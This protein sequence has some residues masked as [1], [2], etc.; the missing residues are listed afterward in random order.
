MSCYIGKSQKGLSQETEAA[1]S[2]EMAYEY[3]KK[4]TAK[5]H[6]LNAAFN[7]AVIMENI[8]VSYTNRREFTV[9][10]KW[11]AREDEFVRQ[12]VALKDAPPA[13]V[14]DMK[15]FYYLD[16][17]SVALGLNKPDEAARAFADYQKT[18]KAQSCEGR[19]DG[20]DFLFNAKRYAEAADAYAVLDQFFDERNM[21][22]S[23][24]NVG[25][26]TG[27]FEINLHAGRKD[28]AMAVATYVFDRLDSIITVQKESDAAELATVYAT[29]QKDA[30][31]AQQQIKLT[32]QRWVATA[33]ALLLLS[34]FFIIYTLNRRR[35]AKHLAEKNVQ[36]Q[37]AH[38]EL[39]TAY[40]QLEETT[41][42]KER[43]ASELRI[44]RD[45]QMS[46]V[47]SLFPDYD[48]IFLKRK[49]RF[50]PR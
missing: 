21:G 44:A 17:A 46:M 5:D 9:A 35:H 2:Y 7:A 19:I 36:L 30:E 37:R 43:M 18:Q 10:E 27:K 41:A 12:F 6:R 28:S 29:Q 38:T 11:L 20:A 24:D 42:Q 32:Q 15:A 13:W 25:F 34:I 45:I 31:I 22:L 1:K 16:Y 48:V 4:M 26:L 14:D 33:I 50:L 47:P 39:Q 3:A 49:L 8:L 40:D 23:L